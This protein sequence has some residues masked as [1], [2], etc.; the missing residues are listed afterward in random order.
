MIAFLREFIPALL[1]G[2]I[3]NLEIAGLALL[4]GIAVASLLIAFR[5]RGG[6]PGACASGVGVLLWAS[7]TFVVMFFLANVV[8]ERWMLLGVPIHFTGLVV[9]VIS[10]AVFA[11]A[12]VT[13]SGLEAVRHRRAGRHGSALL[14]LPQVASA[15]FIMVTS[16]SQAAAIGV[17]DAVAVTLRAGERLPDIRQRV[18]LYFAVV[19][20][21]VAI[22]RTAFRI[23]NI[24][25]AS[26]VR[27]FDRR[28]AD[29]PILTPTNVE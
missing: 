8:P 11:T 9:I 25:R 2:L 23:I 24:C 16:S 19:L 27:R 3:V 7:P 1:A 15:F 17:L 29:G 26:L 28:S 20:L 18:L 10:Q 4:V 22:Q 13:D 5:L 6:L 14:L 12:F 21:F